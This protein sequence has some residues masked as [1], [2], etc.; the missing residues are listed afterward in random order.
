MIPHTQRYCTVR[1]VRVLSVSLS[2][3]GYRHYQPARGD[4][5]A[6]VASSPPPPRRHEVHAMRDTLKH[7]ICKEQV[8]PAA[9]GADTYLVG[10]AIGDARAAARAIQYS[11]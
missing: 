6:S 4:T 11:I 2:S 7:S 10:D 8:A 9:T 3:G 5:D 1:S